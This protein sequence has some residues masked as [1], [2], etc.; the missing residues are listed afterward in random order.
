MTCLRSRRVG[1]F[2]KPHIQ[3]SVLAADDYLQ[4]GTTDTITQESWQALASGRLKFTAA[5]VTTTS[6]IGPM[7][8]V[9][10]HHPCKL[11]CRI[12]FLQKC[13]LLLICS[14]APQLFG[15]SPGRHPVWF[16]TTEV[17]TISSLPNVVSGCVTRLSQS[18]FSSVQRFR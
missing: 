15:H 5:D 13:A 18:R 7:P 1:P 11:C 6:T 16:E 2:S 17:G 3:R 12:E 8:T 9:G 10:N 14:A 4:G